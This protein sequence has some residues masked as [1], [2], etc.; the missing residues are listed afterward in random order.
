M[1]LK[2]RMKATETSYQ[3]ILRNFSIKLF[4]NRTNYHKIKAWGNNLGFLQTKLN[5]KNTAYDD[6]N[7]AER[8]VEDFEFIHGPMSFTNKHVMKVNSFF[9]KKLRSINTNL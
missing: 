8:K 5:F 9:Q 6:Y 2:E 3:K 4:E 7:L 1:S